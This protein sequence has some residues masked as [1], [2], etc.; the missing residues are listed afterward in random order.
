MRHP[1]LKPG[2]CNNGD[3]AELLG[4]TILGFPDPVNF[5]GENTWPVTPTLPMVY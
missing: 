5:S 4:G 1:A 3:L 2:F